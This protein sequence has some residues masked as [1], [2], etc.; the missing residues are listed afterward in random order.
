MGCWSSFHMLIG[1]FTP[2]LEKY[3]FKSL[4]TFKLSCLFIVEC[5]SSS[6]ILYTDP[7]RYK[8][9][10]YL[11]HHNYFKAFL[12]QICTQFL[13]RSPEPKFYCPQT[14]CHNSNFHTPKFEGNICSCTSPSSCTSHPLC[15]GSAILTTCLKRN[16][17]AIFTPVTPIHP[18]LKPQWGLTEDFRSHTPPAEVWQR[19]S[20]CTPHPPTPSARLGDLRLYLPQPMGQDR[21]LQAMPPTATPGPGTEAAPPCPAGLDR[22]GA[23]WVWISPNGSGSHAILRRV[24]AGEDLTLGPAVYPRL[25]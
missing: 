2:S 25:W 5:E 13:N 19:T 21:G 9:C 11:L 18:Y 4:P 15:G 6:F 3:L 20:R 24:W 12:T 16:T 7:F 14:I 17:T 8:I 22:S 10:K 23:D 1:H